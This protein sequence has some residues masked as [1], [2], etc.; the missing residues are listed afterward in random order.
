MFTFSN[1]LSTKFTEI[2]RYVTENKLLL[3]NLALE[4]VIIIL[5]IEKS[6]DFEQKLNH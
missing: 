1:E 2:L 3:L 4:H 5:V 6:F